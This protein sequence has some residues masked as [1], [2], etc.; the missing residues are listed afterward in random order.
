[1]TLDFVE[2]RLVGWILRPENSQNAPFYYYSGGRYSVPTL[3]EENLQ[4][5]I[6][7]E[8]GFHQRHQGNVSYTFI[9]TGK[10][11][12]SLILNIL[13]IILL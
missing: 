6:V 8:L 4:N 13:K 7:M 3:Y 5:S 11:V 12:T 1:M 10:K 9:S 2:K